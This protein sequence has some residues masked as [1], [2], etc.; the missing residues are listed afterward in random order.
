MKK[1]LLIAASALMLCGCYD[2]DVIVIK[3]DPY[4]YRITIFV[5]EV[6]DDGTLSYSRTYISNRSPIVGYR[7]GVIELEDGTVTNA[8]YIVERIRQTEH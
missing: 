4:V 3:K 7:N 6:M 1:L 2:D 5:N 8:P